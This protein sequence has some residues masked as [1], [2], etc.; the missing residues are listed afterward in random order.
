MGDGLHLTELGRRAAVGKPGIQTPRRC[1]QRHGP[2]L[3]LL[4]Q[5]NNRGAAASGSHVQKVLNEVG[6]GTSLMSARK[7]AY[8]GQ[9]DQVYRV[10]TVEGQA[11]VAFK[12]ERNLQR[13][14]TRTKMHN[15][16]PVLRCSC[17][18]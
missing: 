3:P 13:H 6:G 10:H 15:A 12:T 18:V 1:R 8:A 16:Q 9:G 2:H 4:K 5:T 17:D 14:L 11:C 7:A